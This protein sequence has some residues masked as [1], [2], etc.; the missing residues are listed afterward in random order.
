M[1]KP[2][3]H[4]SIA[5]MANTE[6]KNHFLLP[7]L[8]LTGPIEGRLCTPRSHGLPAGCFTCLGNHFQCVIPEK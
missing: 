5:K 7:S 1:R 6:C 3:N 4:K 8:P 2:P